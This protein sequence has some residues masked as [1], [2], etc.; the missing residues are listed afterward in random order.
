[1]REMSR[2]RAAIRESK[3]RDIETRERRSD[4]DAIAEAAATRSM[5]K[6][7]KAIVDLV[8]SLS[9]RIDAL[10]KVVA[11]IEV[12]PIVMPPDVHIPPAKETDLGPILQAV[13][14]IRTDV[15]LS[16]ILSAIQAI[17]I[18]EAKPTKWRL[19]HHRDRHGNITETEAEAE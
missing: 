9:Q 8:G 17:R 11:S 13:R 2:L 14:S 3:L 1:M 12:R 10:E 5:D 7:H 19:I 15:D 18:P 6:A 16:P 4:N